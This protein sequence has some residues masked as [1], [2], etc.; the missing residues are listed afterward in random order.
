MH[1]PKFPELFENPKILIPDI[2]GAGSL[3]ATIDYEKI[4]TNHSFNCCVLKKDLVDVER[5]LGI[6][7]RD[8]DLSAQF[9]LRFILGS[10]NS[11]LITFYFRFSRL[12]RDYGQKAVRTSKRK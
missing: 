11:K 7:E 4:Y 5:N 6:A 1:R 8:A 10:I 9:D 3:N 12:E 2:I